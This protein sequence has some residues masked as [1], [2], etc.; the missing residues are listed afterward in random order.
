ML[1]LCYQQSAEE[2]LLVLPSCDVGIALSTTVDSFLTFTLDKE[3]YRRILRENGLVL[4]AVRSRTRYAYLF[5][6]MIPHTTPVLANTGVASFICHSV[7][8]SPVTASHSV[9]YSDGQFRTGSAWPAEN[10]DVLL[11]NSDTHGILHVACR[12]W[13]VLPSTLNNPDFNASEFVIFT[14]FC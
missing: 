10:C 11:V 8:P 6:I 2:Q 1:I 5:W 4:N 9:Q 7:F 13:T 12:I 3:A 14:F